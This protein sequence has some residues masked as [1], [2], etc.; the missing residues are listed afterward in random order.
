M[1]YFYL[2]DVLSNVTIDGEKIAFDYI[3]TYVTKEEA[4][5][6]ATKLAANTDTISVAVHKWSLD[7]SGNQEHCDGRESIINVKG[8]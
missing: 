4:M 3:N 8:V 5:S 6:A 7:Q 2:V 1:M